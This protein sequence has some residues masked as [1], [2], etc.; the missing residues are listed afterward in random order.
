MSNHLQPQ[1]TRLTQEK[2]GASSTEGSEA[3]VKGKGGNSKD[4]F[5]PESKQMDHGT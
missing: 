5:L 2:Q 1:A 4:P 3:Q